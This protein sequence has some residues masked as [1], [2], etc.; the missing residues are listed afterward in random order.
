MDEG[1]ETGIGRLALL[2]HPLRRRLYEHVRDRNRP[3]TRDEAAETAGVSRNLAAFHLDKLVEA[4][5]LRARHDRPPGHESGPGRN[6]KRYEPADVEVL[7]CVP[8]RRY[9]LAGSLLADAIAAAEDG[10]APASA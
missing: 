5:L 2:E 3:V 6:P 1:L 8:D 7:V 10:E 4:G 9:E